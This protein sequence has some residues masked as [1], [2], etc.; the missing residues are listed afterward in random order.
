MGY[1][2]ATGRGTSRN[3]ATRA[4]DLAPTAFRHRNSSKKSQ[5]QKAVGSSSRSTGVGCLFFLRRRCVGACAMCFGRTGG[6]GEPLA[7]KH[8][9]VCADRLANKRTARASDPLIGTAALP[10]ITRVSPLR[11]SA[12]RKKKASCQPMVSVST[13]IDVGSAVDCNAASLSGDV[14]RARSARTTVAASVATVE[15]V[16]EAVASA[17]IAIVAVTNFAAA[18]TAPVA[19]TI[20]APVACATAVAATKV[21][22][23]RASMRSQGHQ[24][25]F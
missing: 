17:V 5:R 24:A 23:V 11:Q 25:E 10:P 9:A 16:V 14:P 22:L 2:T 15:A 7:Q 3:D 21:T 1:P 6:R 20:A 18:T 12:D 4:R 13:Y 19:F 8:G